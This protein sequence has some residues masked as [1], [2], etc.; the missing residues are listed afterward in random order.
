MSETKIV[1]LGL[2]NPLFTDEGLG[3]HLVHILTPYLPHGVE[4]VDG[5]TDG[6][7]LLAVIE[8][9]SHLLI[10]DAVDAGEVPGMVFEFSG[11]AIPKLY[12]TMFSRHQLGLQEV[13]ALAEI[14]QRLPKK[15][16]LIGV[17]P[18]SLEWGCTLSP[19]V[20][21]KLPVLLNKVNSILH[22]WGTSGL[23]GK[24]MV[25]NN[26]SDWSGLD[27]LTGAGLRIIVQQGS[28][29]GVAPR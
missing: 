10:I 20:A 14:N 7:G 11:N 19:I 28:L 15:M 12:R 5:G 9:A 13:L 8:R 29:A 21:A 16:V 3:V 22:T 25:A 23:P 24:I 4:C 26:Y 17:Q 2:G 6:L 27:P 1:I 18:Y